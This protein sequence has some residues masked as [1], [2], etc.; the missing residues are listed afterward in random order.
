MA[1]L[2]KL[3]SEL[4]EVVGHQGVRELVEWA[5]PIQQRHL[6]DVL[7]SSLDLAGA[8]DPDEIEG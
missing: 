3:E 7:D 8:E 6:K 4:R 1:E 5:L 2:T